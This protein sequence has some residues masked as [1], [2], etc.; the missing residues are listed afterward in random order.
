MNQSESILKIAPALLKA[1][2]GLQA[3]LKSSTNPHFNSK[4]A[5]LK[6]VI[7][8]AQ[9]ALNDNGIAFLQPLS[10]N[11]NRVCI[12]T[13]LLHE[14]GEWLSDI[15]E[16]PLVK[17][18]AQ[19]VGSATTYGKRYSLQAFL[20]IR[21]EDDDGQ[22][23]SEPVQQKAEIKKFPAPGKLPYPPKDL[24]QALND[25]LNQISIDGEYITEDQRQFF[26]EKATKRGKTKQDIVAALKAAG[27]PKTDQIPAE[28][29]DAWISWT[30]GA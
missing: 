30:E 13:V 3:A 26:I 15:L 29:Y 14:S 21:S 20:G 24:K 10:F 6:S 25:S 23:A 5:D 19:A 22:S 17:M 9:P 8:V 2:K 18:D 16:V 1:Q 7:E 27:I 12:T 11:E 28:S 4:F